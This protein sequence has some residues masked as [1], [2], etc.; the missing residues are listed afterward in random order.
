[1]KK[2]RDKYQPVWKYIRM[3]IVLMVL[4][5]AIN[6]IYYKH[7][8]GYTFQYADKLTSYQK[9]QSVP[10]TNESLLDFYTQTSA[11]V[12]QE[13]KN[14]IY[15]PV[16]T[17][18]AFGMLYSGLANESKDQFAKLIHMSNE[19]M[20]A[21]MYQVYEKHQLD[22]LHMDNSMWFQN[23]GNVDKQ[24]L[25][26]ISN[27]YHANSYQTDLQ[28]QTAV[29]EISDYIAYTS[30][31]L[32]QPSLKSNVNERMK[33][34]SILTLEAT[35]EHP[36]MDLGIEKFFTL[37]DGTL[38][39]AN[40]LQSS[41]A[42]PKYVQNEVYEMMDI[43]F[44]NGCTMRMVLPRDINDLS[45]LLSQDSLKQLMSMEIAPL[46]DTDMV[47]T[48]PAF[49][50]TNTFDLKDYLIKQNITS[51]FSEN[52][53]MSAFGDAMYISNIEQIATIDCHADGLHAAAVTMIEGDVAAPMP[54]AKTKLEMN[55]DHPFIYMIFSPSNDLLYIG[56]L[57]QPTI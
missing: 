50:I 20:E 39:N 31:N 21:Y 4:V 48:M 35:W 8:Q 11:Y 28:N 22:G 23:V 37:K 2:V 56:T 51:I 52:K 7:T 18:F 27:M 1:M 45:S 49:R 47:L 13:E 30:H 12:L 42:N 15:S 10:Q 14:S 54:I 29:D 6:Q 36:F 53:D 16:S 55:I 32:L 44:T 33:I 40:K 38:T 24:V 46:Q 5:L 43:S 34:I 26:H 19:D 3:I 41:F 25:Q 17:S 57:Y 9:P